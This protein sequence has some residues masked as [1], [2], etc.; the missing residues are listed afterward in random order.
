MLPRPRLQQLPGPQPAVGQP[1]EQQAARWDR[2]GLHCVAASQLA[3]C[4]AASQQGLENLTVAVML[5][6]TTFLGMAFRICRWVSCV[7]VD[8][9]LRVVLLCLQLQLRDVRAASAKWLWHLCK[10][11]LWL[12]S[13]WLGC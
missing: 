9:R 7:C 11:L 1:C 3:R 4:Q 12:L 8:C 10:S 5:S 6:P 13:T 2:H